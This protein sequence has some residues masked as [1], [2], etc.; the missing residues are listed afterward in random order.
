MPGVNKTFLLGYVG[1]DG[2]LHQTKKGISVVYFSLAVTEP[3]KD[4]KTVWF[5]CALFGKL[6][7]TL[8]PYIL[9]GKMA[10][11]EGKI[12]FYQKEDRSGN[13]VDTHQVFVTSINLI[14]DRAESKP[15][16]REE[17]DDPLDRALA[18]RDIGSD[19]DGNLPF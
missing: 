19:D 10:H 15:K 6:A 11:V 8:S 1:R 9:K 17:L 2:I 13:M 4:Q 5:N 7:E 14:N 18:K 16:M 3:G 12:S